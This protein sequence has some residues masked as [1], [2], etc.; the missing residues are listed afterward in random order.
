MDVSLLLYMLT[1]LGAFV[2]WRYRSHLQQAVSFYVYILCDLW[3]IC[4][5]YFCVIHERYS[6]SQIHQRLNCLYPILR[7][8]SAVV[9]E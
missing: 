9:A 8:T 5:A 4:R 2:L 3:N 7:R 1:A 6:L